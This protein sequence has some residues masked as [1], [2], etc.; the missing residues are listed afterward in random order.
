LKASTVSIVKTCKNPKDDDIRSAVTK[1]VD[2][3]GGIEK[4][5]DPRSKVLVKPN[6]CWAWQELKVTTDPRVT[7]A[8]VELCIKAGAK[9]VFVGEGA[10]VGMDTDKVFDLTGTRE[11]A[12]KAGAKVVD[13]KDIESVSIVNPQGVKMKLF[14]VSKLVKECDTLI[15]V[16]LM[17]IDCPTTF[18]CALKNW[19]GILNDD[20]KLNVLHRMGMYW[21]LSD[22]LGA[23]RQDMIVVDGITPPEV[24]PGGMLR[25]M[26][27]I[28][29]GNDPVAIDAVASKTMGVEPMEIHT[30]RIA[31]E[32]G[33][34]NAS[35]SS[36]EIKGE[37]V[38]KVMV[39]YDKPPR[40]VG[41]LKEDHRFKDINFVDGLACSGCVQAILF[42]WSKKVKPEIMK[43]IKDLTV[44]IGP[45]ADVP[46]GATKVLLLGKCLKHLKG[47]GVLVDGCVPCA[48][49]LMKG[50]K[51]LYGI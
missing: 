11:L 22:L 34:G 4:F 46:T 24:F 10:G 48:D 21:T 36:I 19:A 7:A 2:L 38:E 47:Q 29:A 51:Q 49:D 12:E 26:D 15:N 1:A 40:Y 20:D 33:L 31:S 13:F 18:S 32:R 5:V 3:I 8:V 37:P 42:T 14:K 25:E 23:A 9:E 30:T 17:K 43:R 28:L 35:L 27:L 44:L 50:I 41:E 45:L 16:P 6:M 39:R